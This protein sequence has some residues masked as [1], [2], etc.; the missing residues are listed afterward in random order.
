[1]LGSGHH[2]R[3]VK[4]SRVTRSSLISGRLACVWVQPALLAEAVQLALPRAHSLLTLR[5]LPVVGIILRK[6]VCD[7]QGRAVRVLLP[8]T[9][10]LAP[11]HGLPDQRAGTPAEPALISD[12]DEVLVLVGELLAAAWP[13]AL[14]RLWIAWL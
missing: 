10:V 6:L 14:H 13:A 9:S 1:M 2:R 12:E 11:V 4:V 7:V 8:A 3:V 5:L